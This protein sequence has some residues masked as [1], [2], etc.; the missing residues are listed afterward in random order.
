LLRWAEPP[1]SLLPH[2]FS[3][4]TSQPVMRLDGCSSRIH[5][6]LPIRGALPPRRPAADDDVHG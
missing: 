6:M 1:K 2:T 4:S 3:D 5:P